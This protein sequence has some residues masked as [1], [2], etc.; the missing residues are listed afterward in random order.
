[1][2]SFGQRLKLLREENKMG[3][4]EIASLLG[5]TYSE[6]S[7]YETDLRKP[8]SEVIVILANFFKVSTDYLLG[9]S[10]LRKPNLYDFCEEAKKEIEV[11][12]EFIQHKYPN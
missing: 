9:Q 5:I 3:Q 2:V 6:V 1:M 8:S 10:N 11:F 7:K 4:K 12:I